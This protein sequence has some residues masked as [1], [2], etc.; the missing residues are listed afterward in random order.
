MLLPD[1]RSPSLVILASSFVVFGTPGLVLSSDC[2]KVDLSCVTHIDIMLRFGTILFSVSGVETTLVLPIKF[3]KL[4]DSSK[5]IEFT[6]ESIISREVRFLNFSGKNVG[7]ETL[8]GFRGATP[9]ASPTP[10]SAGTLSSSGM[11]EK[12][13]DLSDFN[14]PSGPPSSFEGISFFL[15]ANAGTGGPDPPLVAAPAEPLLK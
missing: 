7:R 4:S 6:P 5:L 1:S 15:M 8:K 2:S 9:A 10:P 13:I 3:G 12:I 11:C 14:P